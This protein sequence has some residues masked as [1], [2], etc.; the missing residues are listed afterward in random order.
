MGNLYAS[1]T[2]TGD[3]SWGR[4]VQD[5]YIYG[6]RSFRVLSGR[7]GDQLGQQLIPGKNMFMPRTPNDTAA[8]PEAD[9][10]A[11]DQLTQQRRDLDLLVI[12]VAEYNTVT[13]LRRLIE[14][15]LNSSRVVILGWCYSFYAMEKGW[16]TITNLAVRTRWTRQNYH[17]SISSIAEDWNWA[18]NYGASRPSIIVSQ[19]ARW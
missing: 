10:L 12:D 3:H 17:R 16:S 4:V 2:F 19:K 14:R 11:A 13:S 18:M 5:L 15:Y 9:R 1:I 6:Q 8:N 7:H